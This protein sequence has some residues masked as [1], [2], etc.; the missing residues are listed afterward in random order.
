MTI[1][2]I[3]NDKGRTV[4]AILATKTL[5]QAAELLEALPAVGFESALDVVNV[6]EVLV[7]PFSVLF[8][9]DGASGDAQAG[10][11][12]KHFCDALKIV[13]RD[14]QVGV[15]FDQNV[16][17]FI[18]T[19]VADVKGAHHLGTGRPL[20]LFGVV[21]EPDPGEFPGVFL[22]DLGS[23]VGGAV[24]DHDQPF[25]QQR[26]PGNGI[27]RSADECFLIVCGHDDDVIHG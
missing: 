9:G 24:V 6:G 17:I 25:G 7:N 4:I 2:Q 11:L 21:D 3:L 26:L 22:N 14:L 12:F 10:V 23:G 27:Q 18:L 13:G 15:E 8:D 19:F 5:K 20:F 1:D 16:I